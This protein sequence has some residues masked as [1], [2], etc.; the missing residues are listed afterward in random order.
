MHIHTHT[1]T[2]KAHTVT[3][4]NKHTP[5]NIDV[6]QYIVF[7]YTYQEGKNEYRWIYISHIDTQTHTHTRGFFQDFGRRG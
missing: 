4:A 1:H 5:H 3:R 6:L 2:R 7:K